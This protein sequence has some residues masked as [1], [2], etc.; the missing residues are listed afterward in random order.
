MRRDISIRGALEW[1]FGVEHAQLTFDD[2]AE[3]AGE[4]PGVSTIWVM[5]Q[6]G[7]LGCKIDGGGASRPHE[8]AEAIAE[9]LSRL[10]VA[11]GGHGMAVIMAGLARAG[12]AP[13]WM[14]DARPRCVPVAWG[15]ENQN[16]R[17][18]RTEVARVD[19]ILFRGRKQ[20]YEARCCPV[21]Y[22]PSAAQIG[23]ARRHYLNWYG[24][25]LHLRAE[26]V[27]PG[28]L[29]HLRLTHAMPPLSPWRIEALRVSPEQ[30]A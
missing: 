23:A 24:A 15:A 27:Q 1:A 19:E 14:R 20:T 10:P 2:L 8:D 11:L 9:A 28:R 18:A 16:G 29:R 12:V 4:R 17:F 7:Q 22:A 30:A 3:V 13:D 25:L 6:R 5:I 21:T 26:L